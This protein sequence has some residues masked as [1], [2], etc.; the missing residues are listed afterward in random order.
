MTK[1]KMKVSGSFRTFDGAEAFA[2]LR[3]VVSTA[4]KQRQN[5]LKTL[6]A[7]PNALCAHLNI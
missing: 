7:H 1:V 2:T 3:S 4:R 6:T 5:I